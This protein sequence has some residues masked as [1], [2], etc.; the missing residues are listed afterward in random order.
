M[1][2]EESMDNAK[3]LNSYLIRSYLYHAGFANDDGGWDNRPIYEQED[4]FKRFLTLVVM[5][6]ERVV[7]NNFDKFGG[8]TEPWMVPGDLMKHFGIHKEVR[9]DQ[10]RPNPGDVFE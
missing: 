10:P 3:N 1:N 6:C 4:N 2:T 9:E 5:E 7:C 8:E